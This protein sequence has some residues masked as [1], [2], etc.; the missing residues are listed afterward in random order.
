MWSYDWDFDENNVVSF[1]LSSWDQKDENLPMCTLN[2]VSK[3]V[4]FYV[5]TLS[6]N[7]E[8]NVLFYF[9]KYE[10]VFSNEEH[11][12]IISIFNNFFWQF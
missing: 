3:L 9:S 8:N 5:K 1:L 12:N 2:L 4:M 11:V 6:E 10:Q 7:K